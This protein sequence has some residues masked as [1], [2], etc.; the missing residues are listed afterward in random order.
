M[1]ISFN[2]VF[3]AVC[4]YVVKVS[5]YMST[6]SGADLHIYQHIICEGITAITTG[7]KLK[8]LDSIAVSLFLNYKLQ[9]D[10][11]A[12]LELL[13][14]L[15]HSFLQ[16]SACGLVCL[17]ILFYKMKG[18][19]PVLLLPTCLQHSA[20]ASAV[21]YLWCIC[22][23]WWQTNGRLTSKS[24]TCDYHI[25]SGSGWTA[26][27][28]EEDETMLSISVIVIVNLIENICKCTMM[29]SAC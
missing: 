16:A 19:Y 25:W 4:I 11:Q 6:F 28:S 12:C 24:R 14:L 22:N 20:S 21:L 8:Y 27:Q 15:K 3:I 26:L 1:L 5:H 13:E 10:K 7:V 23:N 18:A 2:T 17:A 29:K 9:W